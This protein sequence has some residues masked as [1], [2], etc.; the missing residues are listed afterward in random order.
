MDPQSKLKIVHVATEIAPLAKVGGLGD[1]MLGLSKE[2]IRLGHSSVVFLPHYDCLDMSCLSHIQIIKENF[3]TFFEGTWHKN[4]ISQ[5]TIEGIPVILIDPQHEDSLFRRGSIYGEEDDARRFLYFSRAVFDFLSKNSPVDVIHLHDWQ[6]APLAPLIKKEN[7]QLTKKIVYTIHN[8]AYQG[9]VPGE[10]IESIALSKDEMLEPHA[11]QDP[12]KKNFVNLMK[13]G[14]TF[15]DEITTVSPTFAKEALTKKGG[16]GLDQT[17]KTHK[18]KFSGILNGIDSDFWSPLKDKYLPIHYAPSDLKG[19]FLLQTLLKNQVELSVCDRPLIGCIARLVPQKGLPLI[20]HAIEF[21][22][23]MGGQ[24]ILLGSSPIESINEEFYKLKEELKNNSNVHL[25]LNS[26]EEMAHLIFAACDMFIVPSCFEPCGLTQMIALHYGTVPVVRKTG[27]LA[28]TVFDI[29][30]SSLP[31]EKRNGYTF[32][33]EKTADFEKALLRAFS[34]W[35]NTPQKWQHLIQKGM[36]S[37]LSW[38]DPAKKY[39]TLYQ[40]IN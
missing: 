23:K 31:E 33:T 38:T 11:L 8:L 35:K 26:Q 17:L 16:F 39:V 15:S 25:I 6:V 9:V 37:D 32:E 28:D 13:G 36:S 7:P 14:I 5:T 29:D 20:R 34:C 1:V 18:S 40:K 10:Q 3:L 24:F 2:L 19:K 30:F 27:G 22:P 4:T 21:I 12:T